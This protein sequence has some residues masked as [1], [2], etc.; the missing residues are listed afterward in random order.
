ML[1]GEGVDV[2]FL[3]GVENF[4]SVCTIGVYGVTGNERAA[5][6]VSKKFLEGY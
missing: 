2:G 3:P 6:R 5:R 1:R 4:F